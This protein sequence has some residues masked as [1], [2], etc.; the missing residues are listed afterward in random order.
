LFYLKPATWNLKPCGEVR[1]QNS[2]KAP[3]GGK[4]FSLKPGTWNLK[5]KR[6]ASALGERSYRTAGTAFR[7]RDAAGPLWKPEQPHGRTRTVGG[8]RLKVEG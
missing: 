7:R 6:T 5:P 1:G 3:K 4:G 2:G 8:F